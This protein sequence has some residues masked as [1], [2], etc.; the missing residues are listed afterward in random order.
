[1]TD[2]KI[3]LAAGAAIL[4]GLGLRNTVLYLAERVA[5]EMPR[6][7][8]AA[9]PATNAPA[10]TAP[11]D[12]QLC[13]QISKETRWTPGALTNGILLILG[14]S[15]SGKTESMKAVGQQLIAQGYPVLTFD[16]H[17]DVKM[18][19]QPT[20]T[21][22]AA[23][24]DTIGINPLE[25]DAEGAKEAGLYDHR[26]TLVEIIHRAVPTLGHNQ[27]NMLHD[28]LAKAYLKQGIRDEDAATWGLPAPTCAELLA[29]MKNDGLIAGVRGLFGHP[30]FNRQRN[31]AIADLMS[32]GGRIDLSKLQSDGIRYIITETMLR[33]IFT[34]AK[35]RGSIPVK[36]ASDR[37]RFRLFLVID[38]ARLMTMGGPSDIMQRLA[39]EGRK[40]GLGMLFASQSV[41][42]FPHDIRNSAASLLALRPQTMREA[43]INAKQ[44]GVP[45][46]ALLG[47]TGKG[48]G[49][50]KV[51]AEPVRELRVLQYEMPAG[52]AHPAGRA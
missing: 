34:A 14:S 10:Q 6:R 49:F 38:E 18:R 9:P 2:L 1:M 27:I 15:G 48:H 8:L 46:E 35:L 24:G 37:E 29:D 33:R 32:S 21:L 25:I 5:G 26:Q 45:P 23:P 12:G 52:N 30:V 43:T 20:Y 51:G 7:L 36:P 17:G 39:N 4:V 11:T 41:E 40:F 31:I 44:I 19:G 3:P 47:L 50:W 13:V 28:I 42:H 16:F 22:S